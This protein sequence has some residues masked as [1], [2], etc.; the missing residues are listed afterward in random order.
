M[1][2]ITQIKL[3]GMLLPVIEVEGLLH[4]GVS[5]QGRATSDTAKIM[6]DA[7]CAGDGYLLTVLHEAVHQAVWSLGV[8]AE[9]P[10]I[11]RIAIMILSLIRDN[12]KLVDMIQE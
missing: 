8:A 11:D 1:K 4:K 9:E 12:P 3:L 2:K 6:I 7:G 5:V 10:D